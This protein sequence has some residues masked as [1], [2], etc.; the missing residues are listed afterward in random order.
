MSAKTTLVWLTSIAVIS[1]ALLHPFYPQYF[2]EV[3]GIRSAHHVGLYVAASSLTVLLAFPLWARVAAAGVSV[4]RLLVVTQVVAALFSLAA[5]AVTSWGPFW[6]LSLAMLAFKASYLLI[7]PFVLSLEGERH[8]LGTISLLAFVVHAG[9]TVAA[10]LA[11]LVMQWWPA[12]LLFVFMALGDLLQ[13]AL[14]LRLF[15]WRAPLQAPDAP[16]LET[17]VPTARAPSRGEVLRLGVVMFVLC[18]GGYL[19]EPFFAAY[20]EGVSRDGHRL[21]SGFAFAVPGLAALGALVCNRRAAQTQAP[22]RREIGLALVGAAV[23]LLLQCHR[24]VP[25]LLLGR[26]LFGWAAF[27]ATV[28]LDLL[29]FRA[30]TPSRYALD[31]GQINLAQGLGVLLASCAAGPLFGG[32]GGRRP[33][34]VAALALLA[35]VGLFSALFSPSRNARADHPSSSRTTP[36]RGAA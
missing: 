3:L 1:D 17:N 28:R 5:G 6:L 16:E 10:L 30:S 36:E 33:F 2:A 18:F 26:A 23:G 19:T 21:L 22:G 24:E 29:L 31:F 20:W 35:N 13:T 14:C 7:Y 4:F 15:S 34:W 32:D 27:Q 11:G 8:H 9:S 25:L 12:R